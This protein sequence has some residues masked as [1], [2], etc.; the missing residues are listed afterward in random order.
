MWNIYQ[1]FR[2]Q[3]SKECPFPKED[4]DYE[5]YYNKYTRYG[6]R[7]FEVIQMYLEFMLSI[8]DA[9]EEIA[10]EE[11]VVYITQRIFFLQDIVPVYWNAIKGKYDNIIKILWNK[12]YLQNVCKE[13]FIKLNETFKIIT[14]LPNIREL[15]DMQYRLFMCDKPTMA[16]LLGYPL[17]QGIFLMMNHYIMLLI[18]LGN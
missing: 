12:G 18:C 2:D 5:D 16:Y 10:Q 14:Y 17:E 6:N 8:D 7:D 4:T 9:I 1:A 15:T 13:E 11:N 3:C